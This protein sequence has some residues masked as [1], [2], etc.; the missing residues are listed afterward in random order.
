MLKQLIIAFAGRKQSGK[1]SSCNYFIA[2]YLNQKFKD[3]SINDLG[4]L[5]Y[6]NRVTTSFPETNI[7]KVYSFADPLKRFCIEVLNAPYESC[8]GTDEQKNALI[9]HLLWQNLP[10]ELISKTIKIKDSVYQEFSGIVREGYKYEE[11]KT[12]PMSGRELMQILGTNFCRKLY[13]DC[14]VRATYETIKREAFPIALISDCRFQN[15]LYYPRLHNIKSYYIKL[16]K[17]P[18]KEDTHASETGLDSVPDSDFD[19]VINNENLSLKE[20]CTL[21]DPI[22]DK[23]ILESQ[24]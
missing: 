6:C 16:K 21:L 14:W 8:Y 23:L 15:E 2:K 19:F 10:K 3:Y 7:L 12:G 18:F 13:D 17:A 20:K 11:Y 1:S 4:E 5:T 9:P 22:F 24:Q